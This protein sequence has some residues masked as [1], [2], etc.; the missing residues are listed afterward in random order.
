MQIKKRAHAATMNNNVQTIAVLRKEG[1]FGNAA[2]I[3]ACVLKFPKQTDRAFSDF[4][5]LKTLLDASSTT[6]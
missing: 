5:A 1:A 2:R 3:C 6:L 4:Q